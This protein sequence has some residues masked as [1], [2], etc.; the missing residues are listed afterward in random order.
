[1]PALGRTSVHDS[2]VIKNS[3][4]LGHQPSDRG[5]LPS[6]SPAVWNDGVLD[7]G[8]SEIDGELAAITSHASE[9]ASLVSTP[10]PKK[11]TSNR[12]RAY[13]F[14]GYFKCGHFRW[15]GPRAP[16]TN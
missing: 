12:I 1:M 7:E 4:P 11:L 16:R 2:M 3:T 8:Y 5:V 9:I 6:S 15:L 13:E 10:C 14:C